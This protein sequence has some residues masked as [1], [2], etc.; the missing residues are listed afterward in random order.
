MVSIPSNEMSKLLHRLRIALVRA[1]LVAG[2]VQLAAPSA[3]SKDLSGCPLAL[4]ASSA[5]DAD[6]SSDVQL[7]GVD[8]CAEA[9]EMD[10]RRRRLK[11]D[12]ALPSRV[13]PKVFWEESVR[14]RV[15]DR[16]NCRPPNRAS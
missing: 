10:A 6:S 7:H 3:A 8:S 5:G 11:V 4:L 15:E 1:L 9:D 12:S 16:R 14:I 2:I 13:L